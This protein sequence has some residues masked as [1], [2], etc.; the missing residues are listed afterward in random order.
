MVLLFCSDWNESHHN[1]SGPEDNKFQILVRIFI[2]R[3]YR[4]VSR[5][6]GSVPEWDS[7]YS[8]WMDITLYSLQEKNIS[9]GVNIDDI[10]YILT[11]PA[12]ILP[13]ICNA[14]IL[15]QLRQYHQQKFLLQGSI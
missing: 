9:E 4:S 15:L 14:L 10:N 7:H 8:D 1:L 13:Y 11:T 12:S 5:N 3:F 2:R 6:L